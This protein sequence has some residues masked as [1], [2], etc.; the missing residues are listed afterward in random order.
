MAP[1]VP[2]AKFFAL[3][4]RQLAKPI[5][6]ILIR[7]TLTHPQARL[8]CIRIGNVLNVVNLKISRLA[9]G[10]PLN[11]TILPI[12]EEKALDAGT[13]F[14]GEV[15]VFSVGA[16]LLAAELIRSQKK[17]AE[18]ELAK[19]KALFYKELEMKASIGELQR[20]LKEMEN[21]IE[22]SQKSLEI[23]RKLLPNPPTLRNSLS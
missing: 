15:F 4:A 8:R 11:K 9:E 20:K 5:S 21:Q 13:T 10:Q 2:V 18:N 16:S 23:F 7:Y 14:L 19:E 17:A 12:S 22:E 1:V 3:A 6:Q